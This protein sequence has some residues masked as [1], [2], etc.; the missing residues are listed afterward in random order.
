M[1]KFE[2]AGVRVRCVDCNLFT[3]EKRCSG[4]KHSPKVSAR[5]RRVCNVYQFKGEYENRESLESMYVPWIDSS[6]KKHMRRMMKSGII[7]GMEQS[8]AIQMPQ[9]TASPGTRPESPLVAPD[10]LS[11]IWTP[12]E[13]DADDNRS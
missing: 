8:R 2:G 12:E 1:G 13:N 7:P 4:K 3:P 5:K 11:L 6:T 10:D 9:S